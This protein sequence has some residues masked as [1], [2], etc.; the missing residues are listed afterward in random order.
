MEAHGWNTIGCFKEL[1]RVAG[2]GR[3]NEAATI[4]HMALGLVKDLQYLN[5]CVLRGRGED[6]DDVRPGR[7]IFEYIKELEAEIGLISQ[8]K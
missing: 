4:A 8:K 1:E 3:K 6:I 7:N 5:G 2:Q